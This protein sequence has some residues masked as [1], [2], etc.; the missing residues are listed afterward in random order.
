MK[1]A[2]GHVPAIVAE[3]FDSVIMP[4][5]SAAGGVKAFAVG[6]VGGLVARQ[7]P[8][9]IE[10]FL[11]TAKALGLVDD[12]NFLDLD[13][14]YDEAAKAMS[15]SPLIVAGYRA[16]KDDLDKIKSIASKYSR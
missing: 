7:T 3:Y 9:M 2:I 14:A 4:S 8:V 6:F 1:V 5:A 16:D 15:R 11:P 10:Q 12:E 13:L